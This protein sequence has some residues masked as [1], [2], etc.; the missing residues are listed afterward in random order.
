MRNVFLFFAVFIGEFC[1]AQKTIIYC[2]KLIDVKS[3]QILSEMSIVVEG[4][5]IID[6]QKGFINPSSN[7]QVIDLKNK[8]VMPGLIDSHV[9]LECK[10]YLDGWVHH[11]S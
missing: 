3:L 2:G 9:H 6:I 1:F 4:N 10:D 5:K 11:S 7:D 8:T